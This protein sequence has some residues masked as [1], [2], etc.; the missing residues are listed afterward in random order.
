MKIPLVEIEMA[1]ADF[2]LTP[3]RSTQPQMDADIRRWNARE[4]ID[5]QYDAKTVDRRSADYTDYA[6]FGPWVTSCGIAKRAAILGM[7]GP[8]SVGRR[9]REKPKSV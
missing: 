1:C 3:T 2:L 6:D 8:N 7:A 9:S 4:Y 5:R